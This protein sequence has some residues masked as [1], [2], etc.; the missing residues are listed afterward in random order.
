MDFFLFYYAL[1]LLFL[2]LF[3]LLFIYIL[4]SQ[5]CIYFPSMIYVPQVI[6][7]V[8]IY[9]KAIHTYRMDIGAGMM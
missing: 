5:E 9:I 2:E 8:I 7:Q 1:A 3:Y 4:S 6:P